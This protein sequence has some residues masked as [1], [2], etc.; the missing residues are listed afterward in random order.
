M[1]DARLKTTGR[2]TSPYFL[3][4][5]HHILESEQYARLSSKAVKL[6]LDLGGQYR[7]KNN[8]DLSAAWKIMERRGWRSRD[9]LVKALKELLDSGFIIKTRQGG[10]NKPCLYAL[11][12]KGID[13]CRGKLDMAPASVPL[14][15][16]KSGKP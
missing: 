2:R 13:E 6:L 5:P 9:T 1:A 11:T 15:L 7:G 12:W 10:K 3:A 4:M 14:N 8:G 16:W